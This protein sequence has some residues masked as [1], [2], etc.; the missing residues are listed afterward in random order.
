MEPGRW[1]VAFVTTQND[2]CWWSS[3]RHLGVSLSGGLAPLSPI[4]AELF[5]ISS[6]FAS[7]ILDHPFFIL[8]IFGP[9][10]PVHLLCLFQN[11]WRYPQKH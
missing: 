11:P 3:P 4:E 5:T 10:A 8:L 7:S 1:T 9:L 2:Q 6:L